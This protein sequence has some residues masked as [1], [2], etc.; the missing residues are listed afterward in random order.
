M[1]KI[2]KTLNGIRTL[3]EI[4]ENP[5]GFAID[6]ILA[7]I[8]SALIP[9]P[10]SGAVVARYRN[11][12]L[13]GLGEVLVLFLTFV[14]VILSI[15]NSFSL[16]SIANRFIHNSANQLQ[17]FLGG[18]P[19]QALE[20]YIEAGFSDTN[21]PRRNPLGGEVMENSNVTME[22]HDPNYHF[23][24]GIHTGIDLIPSDHY[25]QTNEAYKKTNQLIVF[26][27]MNGKAQ[28]YVDQYGA[29]VVDIYNS[30]NTILTRYVH[31]ATSFISSG[32]EVKAGQPVGIMGQTGEATGVHL[33]YEIRV[34]QNGSMVT[35][36]PRG[37][38]N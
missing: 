34:D 1:T 5:L 33:H 15:V 35:V 30:D 3:K 19:L 7:T 13:M 38:I 32:Q 9:I 4:K 29:N 11:Y 2:A 31:L 24:D 28:F 12:I 10:F 26:A 17:G 14:F 27:T 25:F 23:F 20:G 37:Y 36:N 18:N 16:S 22:Y 21:T 8:I 6:L